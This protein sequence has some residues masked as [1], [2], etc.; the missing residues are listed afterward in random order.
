LPKLDVLPSGVTN[1]DEMDGSDPQ[2]CSDN[3]RAI[4]IYLRNLE[5]SQPIKEDFLKV[6]HFY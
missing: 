3:V 5:L 4:Y 6:T 2:L 1:V